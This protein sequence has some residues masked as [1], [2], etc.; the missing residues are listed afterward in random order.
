MVEDD[1]KPRCEECGRC[2]EYGA[3]MKWIRLKVWMEP[4]FGHAKFASQASSS[5]FS[6]HRPWRHG[7]PRGMSRYCGQLKNQFSKFSPRF[8]AIACKS[9]RELK[10]F[11]FVAA[12]MPACL[13]VS[14][15]AFWEIRKMWNRKEREK[16]HRVE[17]WCLQNISKGPETISRLTLSKWDLDGSEKLFFLLFGQVR[18]N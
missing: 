4:A 11:F 6:L 2:P 5:S 13:L 14:A 18:L 10:K 12:D 17:C 3:M 15:G 16:S 7:R 1:A 8:A 9:M